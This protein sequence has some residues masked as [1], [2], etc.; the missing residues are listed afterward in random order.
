MKR[1]FS[2]YPK[3]KISPSFGIFQIPLKANISFS[4]EKNMAN[5]NTP[6]TAFP[7]SKKIKKLI[8]EINLSNPIPK[9]RRTEG[10]NLYECQKLLREEKLKNKNYEDNIILLNRQIDELQLRLQN[11][12]CQK[13]QNNDVNDE[14]IK[15]RQEN[16]D[17]KLFKEKVYE[18]SIKYD[19]LNKDILNCLKSI[20]KIVQIYNN[21]NL[22][23][24]I[25]FKYNNLNKISNNFESI[26]N[27]LTNFMTIKQEEYN[28]LLIEK[29]KEIE[30][31]KNEINCSHI[32]DFS[33][34]LKSYK[35]LGNRRKSYE[36]NNI[37]KENKLGLTNHCNKFNTVYKTNEF[38]Y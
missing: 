27:N 5:V 29:E 34:G 8:E 33:Y 12:C 10:T 25:D 15:L 16:Q 31:I 3:N 36:Y 24:N 6:R 32:N 1:K 17:L 28:T 18:F 21:D 14:L 38:N 4:S 20:E 23:Q 30:K 13:C 9:N 35:E 22:S 26:I 11:Y 19:E 2:L 7:K 37:N